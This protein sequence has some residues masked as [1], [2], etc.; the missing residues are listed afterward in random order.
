[1]IS[2]VG[3]YLSACSFY[4]HPIHTHLN[5]I[6]TCVHYSAILLQLNLFQSSSNGFV[7]PQLSYLFTTF[8]S[9]EIISFL[10]SLYSTRM[11][12]SFSVCPPCYGITSSMYNNSVPK[13]SASC[14]SALYTSSLLDS[15][16]NPEVNPEV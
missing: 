2:R 15:K 4:P 5:S 13:P 12:H 10:T 11:L 7:S 1:M 14:I 16:I 3:S 9:S 6:M 8:C